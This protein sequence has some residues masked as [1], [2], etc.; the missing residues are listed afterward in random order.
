[1]TWL[2]SLQTKYILYYLIWNL[3]L[4]NIL[5]CITLKFSSY[6]HLVLSWINSHPP[7]I[8]MKFI[9]TIFNLLRRINLFV[10]NF[11]VFVTSPCMS[12]KLFRRMKLFSPPLA[13]KIAQ[14]I[15]VILINNVL[16]LHL[17]LKIVRIKTI[18]L[19]LIYIIYI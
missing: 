5:K 1:M 12:S 18:T 10:I 3:I 11:L 9:E 2:N 16:N 7:P 4:T 13:N 8:L 17:F 14:N 6:D 15:V 19:Y